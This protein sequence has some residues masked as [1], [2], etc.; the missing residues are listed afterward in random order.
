MLY[1][2]I[3]L[4]EIALHHQSWEDI[5]LVNVAFIKEFTE[6]NFIMVKTKNPLCTLKKKKKV[7]I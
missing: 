2:T 6:F 3:K 5:K 1:L 7:L 4:L